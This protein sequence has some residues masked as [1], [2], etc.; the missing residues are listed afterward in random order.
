MIEL[1]TLLVGFGFLF[2]FKHKV[3]K[4]IDLMNDYRLKLYEDKYHHL[5]KKDK[6]VSMDIKELSRHIVFLE[7]ELVKFTKNKE[8]KK[9]IYTL[10][11][12]K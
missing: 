6:Q 5:L 7:K 9:N 1:L 3:D 2:Y 10:K 8:D 12:K 11:T 4:K